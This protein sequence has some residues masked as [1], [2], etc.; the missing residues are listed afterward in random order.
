MSDRGRQFLLTI[1]TRVRLSQLRLRDLRK[2]SFCLC[3]RSVTSMTV[4]TDS[5]RS[6]ASRFAAGW[7]TVRDVP[8]GSVWKNDFETQ[9]QNRFFHTDCRIVNALLGKR[10]ILG[11]AGTFI[12]SIFRATTVRAA[13][14]P[15]KMRKSSRMTKRPRQWKHS[16]PNLPAWLS[17]CASAK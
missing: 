5:T 4:P 11:G 1:I 13:S 6:S 8:Y 15:K 16:K 10:P 12:K 17:L 14:K 7:P 9:F 2:A 3:F